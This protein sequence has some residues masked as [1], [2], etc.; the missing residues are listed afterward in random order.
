MTFSDLEVVLM[1]ALAVVV[2]FNNRLSKRLD[3]HREAHAVILHTIG[4]VADNKARFYRNKDGSI[5]CKSTNSPEK[6]H[7]TSQQ[8]G[9]G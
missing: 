8:A 1:V 3:I 2:Y 4:V 7:E 9:Q 5:G 6:S